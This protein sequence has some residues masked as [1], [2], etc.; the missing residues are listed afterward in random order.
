[1]SKS[2]LGLTALAAVLLLGCT[3]GVSPP[4][5]TMAQ[6]PLMPTVTLS[7]AAG[8]VAAG[9]TTTLNWSSTD[10]SSCSA[11]GAWA[12]SK[13]TSGSEATAAINANS[14]F[15]LS[16]TGNGGT[17]M[18][19]T[20]VT[21][22]PGPAVALGAVPASVVAG[23]TATLTWSSTNAASCTASGGW[24]GAQATSGSASTAA[25]NADTT[26]TL[27]CTG[28]G[29]MAAATTTVTVVTT[30]SVTLSAAPT[31]VVA[32]SSSTLTWGSANVT[33]CT[34]SGGWNGPM[35]TSGS[36]SVGP[37]NST[38]T[39]TLTCMGTGG[40]A[41]ATAT[42]TVG[43]A[44][45][46]VS[47]RVASLTFTQTQQF[48]ATAPGGGAVTW[49][50]DGV[51]G[52]NVSVGTISSSGLYVPPQ[53]AGTHSITA[54]S[55]A[56]TS[57]S[58]TA[59]AAITDLA[60]VYTYH[61]DLART[62]Q[63][64]QEYALTKALVSGGNFGKRWSCALD[65]DVYAQPLYVANLAIAGGTHNVVFVATNHDSV[66][67]FDG[68]NGSCTPLWKTSFL[69][70]GA[71]TIPAGDYP[72][73][74]DFLDEYGIVGT[75]VI[76]SVSHT[77]Y[78][79][80]TTKESGSYVQ[81][82][83]ALDLATGSEQANSPRVLAPSYP[84][85]SGTVNFDP[86]MQLQRAGL[87]Y[88][89]GGVF[90][91]WSSH[92]DLSTYYGWMA[93]YDGTTLVQTAAF[94]VAPNGAQGGIWMSGAAPAIDSNGS[95][96]LSTGNGSF[97]NTS[98]GLPATPP[99][100]DFSMSFLNFDPSTLTL[101]DFY[102]PSQEAT[103]SAGD[104]DISAPGVMVLPDGTGPTGHPN[105]LY[106]GDK[107]GHIW[108]LDRLR[109]GDF[110]PSSDNVVQMIDV[111][112][113]AVTGSAILFAPP[114]YFS[115]RV[116]ASP[117][118]RPVQAMALT[119]GLFA[120]Q[121]NITDPSIIEVIAQ[122][123]TADRCDFPGC[124]ISISAAGSSEPIAWTLDNALFGKIGRPVAPAVLRAYDATNL[125]SRLF[126]S[127]ASANDTSGNALKFTLP[128]IANGHVYVGGT[129][130]LT[131]YGIAP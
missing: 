116:Y 1:M 128:M 14:T 3:S 10:A 122:S 24:G 22:L 43:A 112:N 126:T 74:N 32:G 23:G 108:L 110:S 107:Q 30:P 18:G 89:S 105:L 9:A 118:T 59:T 7:A 99:A 67:A 83:H 117:V 78:V 127:A 44:T 68:D 42:V 25:I 6:A 61:N 73:C 33:S 51:S 131:V 106:G 46:T 129:K 123:M 84:S 82:L 92:C 113:L 28:A 34:A 39:Y 87:V 81:R 58:G 64:L 96:Y 13:T 88:S 4:S 20:T 109:L 52:G 76:D 77:L 75:P 104:Y 65:G 63:N 62:G 80:A 66:Y 125:A 70:G 124:G 12:G 115:G 72:G 53:A 97:T 91:A 37:I 31:S 8:S 35:A 102:T 95:I 26:Y 11:T 16:C 100:N 19:S 103:W 120:T 45:V 5:N 93:R 69:T 21:L 98:G 41:A 60:G 55:V 17:A 29:G 130:Q 119:G 111:V 56:N 114:A 2:L 86:K 79:V 48:T 57:F 85:G 71:T 15:T 38:T 94:N 27:S 49:S 50:I 90:V 47:P 36:T 54:T 121:P 40:Q 101:N